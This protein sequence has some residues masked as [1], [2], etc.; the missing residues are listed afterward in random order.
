M[1]RNTNDNRTS[2]G[3]ARISVS[4]CFSRTTWS[5]EPSA[6]QNLL[7]IVTTW[8]LSKA[9]FLYDGPLLLDVTLQNEHKIMTPVHLSDPQSF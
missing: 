6:R 2:D 3:I 1:H 7:V 8:Q 4:A 9:F 5:T